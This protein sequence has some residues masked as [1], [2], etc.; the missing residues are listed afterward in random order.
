MGG[1][2]PCFPQGFPCPVV[3]WILPDQLSISPTRLSRS[4]G[5]FPM[6]IRLSIAVSYGSPQPRYARIPVWAPSRSLAATWEI[7]VSFFSS[8]YL[9]VSVHQVPSATLWIHV[10]VPAVTGGFP[11]SDISGSML[12]CSSPELFA[13]YHVFHRLSVPRHPPCAFLRLTFFELSSDGFPPVCCSRI[14]SL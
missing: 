11:H 6:T 8:A 13:A 7:E 5:G 9:D 10:T 3:L 1:G 14:R 4:M 2:P 12:M